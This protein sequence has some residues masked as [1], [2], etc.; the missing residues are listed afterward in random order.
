MYPVSEAWVKAHGEFLAPEGFIELSCYIPEL[1][2]T[3]VY[4]K[5]DLMAFLHQ[6][7]ASPVSGELPKNHI[8]FSLDNSDGKWNP[9]NPVGLERYLSERLRITVRYGF[10]INGV[11]EWIPGGVFYLSE[12]RTSLNGLEASFVARDLLEYMIDKPFVPG[13]HETLY[14]VAQKA[15]EDA[16]LPDDAVVYIS[17]KLTR[18]QID[19]DKEYTGNE[20]VAEILQKCANATNC[21]MYQDRDGVLRIEEPNYEDCGYVIPI[22][23]SYTYPEID[24]AR[25]MKNISVTYEDGLSVLYQ[26]GGSGETQTIA[27]DFI[28]ADFQAYDVAEWTYKS[29][30]TRKQIRGSFRGDPRLD[31][32]DIVKVESKYG[33]MSG[34]ML[35][36]IKYTFSGVFKASYS[37]YIRGNGATVFV[38][39]NEVYTGEVV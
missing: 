36:D 28:T 5:K 25:P 20:S 19:H 38:F 30:R 24:F 37:G 31:V 9:S 16:E 35:T 18:Y 8:E 23:L 6:Q 15:I 39:C 17:D 11:V 13:S 22:N 1:Q 27:N 21:V 12:W 3:L 33:M 7:T 10:D 32:L 2:E 29:L 26:I 34:V 4:T 14:D